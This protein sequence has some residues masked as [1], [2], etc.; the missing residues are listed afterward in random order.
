MN[1]GVSHLIR[2]VLSRGIVTTLWA[3]LCM[4]IGVFAP[5]QRL[6]GSLAFFT[7]WLLGGCGAT[8]AI[9]ERP[10]TRGLMI[11]SLLNLL[12][13][14]GLLTLSWLALSVWRAGD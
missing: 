9:L 13:P 5:E 7:L 2:Y 10:R 6:L 4:L 3:A 14:V 8:V 12:V 1:T 11:G